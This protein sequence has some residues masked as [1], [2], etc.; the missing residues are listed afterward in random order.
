MT[1]RANAVHF[2]HDEP[3]N[4]AL[5]NQRDVKIE[6]LDRAIAAFPAMRTT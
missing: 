6:Q 1:P 2:V 3:S 4:V 5:L